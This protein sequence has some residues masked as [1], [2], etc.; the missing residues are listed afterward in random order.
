MRIYLR[1]RTY[2]CTMEIAPN[3]ILVHIAGFMDNVTLRNFAVVSHTMLDAAMATQ[4]NYEYSPRVDIIVDFI[5]YLKSLVYY[6][7]C[8][9]ECNDCE[10]YLPI[11]LTIEG[12]YTSSEH[13]TTTIGKC[14]YGCN[15]YCAWC[16][17]KSARYENMR[18][19]CEKSIDRLYWFICNLCARRHNIKSN[20]LEQFCYETNKI[21]FNKVNNEVNNVVINEIPIF[22][23]INQYH[24]WMINY[25]KYGIEH[26]EPN[27]SS[28]HVNGK[29]I[30]TDQVSR[31][32][33]YFAS[34]VNTH[35]DAIE[36]V[37]GLFKRV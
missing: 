16:D 15:W 34:Y 25:V 17:K 22:E 11:D 6:P 35:D 32:R 33:K 29:C 19:M 23:I 13:G 27:G 5:G 24:P 12:E 37:R 7:D 31:V 18:I 3:E 8:Y 14:R 2:T 20:P 36:S 21:A 30:A 10:D 26:A 1:L 4:P 28:Y 9:Y